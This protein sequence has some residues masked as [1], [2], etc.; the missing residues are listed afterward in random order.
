M[1][2]DIYRY[3]VRA[4]ALSLCFV[5]YYQNQGDSQVVDG[6]ISSCDSVIFIKSISKESYPSLI[7][8]QH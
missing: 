8:I 3:L 1:Y 6:L 2:L 5:F 7:I 4:L